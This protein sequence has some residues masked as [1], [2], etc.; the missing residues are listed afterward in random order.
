MVKGVVIHSPAR[1]WDRLFCYKKRINQN[2][3]H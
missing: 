1:E 2:E 3:S